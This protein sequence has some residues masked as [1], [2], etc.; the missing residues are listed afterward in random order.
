MTT[1][2]RRQCD[3]CLRVESDSDPR[4]PWY[5]IGLTVQG[6]EQPYFF[7]VCGGCHLQSLTTVHEN[8]LKNI[9]DGHVA[10]PLGKDHFHAES[11]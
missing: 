6:D 8:I 10:H 3:V 11:N 1:I 5:L 2:M 7:D 4:L 9:T